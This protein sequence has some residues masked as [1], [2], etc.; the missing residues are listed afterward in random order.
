M[1]S[2]GRQLFCIYIE[3]ENVLLQN[4]PHIR[5]YINA[6]QVKCFKLYLQYLYAGEVKTYTFNL[7]ESMAESTFGWK[8]CAK[9]VSDGADIVLKVNKDDKEYTSDNLGKGGNEI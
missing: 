1:M 7:S 3:E 9:N 5:D 8:V 2:S 6:C 4:I